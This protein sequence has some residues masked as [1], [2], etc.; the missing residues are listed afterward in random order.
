M[1]LDQDGTASVDAV[2]NLVYQ[3]TYRVRDISEGYTHTGGLLKVL[4]D[5]SISA[6][7]SYNA[8]PAFRAYLSWM[9]DS[10]IFAYELRKRHSGT[11]APPKSGSGTEIMF[12]RSIHALLSKLRSSLWPAILRKGYTILSIICADLLKDWSELSDQPFQLSVCRGLLSMTDICKEH[13]SMRRVMSLH[14]M[15]TIQDMLTDEET[16][17]SLESDMRVSRIALQDFHVKLTSGR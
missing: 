17:S 16:F 8:T 6:A 5:V 1:F 15:P 2:S 10:F 3:F 12:F 14:L 4:V 11:L 9:L 13:E 7:E